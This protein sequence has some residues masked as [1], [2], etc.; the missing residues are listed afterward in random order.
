M[1]CDTSSAGR[2][3]PCQGWGHEFEPRYPLQNTV[4]DKVRIPMLKS[5]EKVDVTALRVYLSRPN[6]SRNKPQ[7]LMSV[8]Q[9]YVSPTCRRLLALLTSPVGQVL[10]STVSCFMLFCSKHRRDWNL[11]ET[12]NPLS[13]DLIVFN[14]R[15][16]VSDT[17]VQ[18]EHKNRILVV[19]MTVIPDSTTSV[20]CTYSS[21]VD[22]SRCS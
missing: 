10:W 3:Q 1:W 22:L 11:Y 4:R 21:S 19:M 20:L 14:E 13:S 7:V 6:I 18:I 15:L 12:Y 5:P 16:G 2:A 17:N 8:S 9:H